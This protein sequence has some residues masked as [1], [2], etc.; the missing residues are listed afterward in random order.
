MA[1]AVQSN[2]SLF[3]SVQRETTLQEVFMAG[4]CDVANEML[5]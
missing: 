3:R 2:F 5:L 1:G 4:T